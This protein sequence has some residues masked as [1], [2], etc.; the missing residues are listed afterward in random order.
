MVY[1]EDDFDDHDIG[2]YDDDSQLFITVSSNM[3]MMK[4]LIK[5]K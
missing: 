1:S 3:M 4:M 5:L 2:C